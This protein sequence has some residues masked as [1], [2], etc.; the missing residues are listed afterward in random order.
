[1]R[2]WFFLLSGWLG[3]AP[4]HVSH[5]VPLEI[6]QKY[7]DSQMSRKARGQSYFSP[8]QI[9]ARDFVN[10]K[11]QEWTACHRFGPQGMA[12]EPGEI[13][14]DLRAFVENKFLLKSLRDMATYSLIGGVVE[15]QPWSGDYWPYATGILG[16]RPFDA[17]F[18]KL[19]NW[20]ERFQFVNRSTAADLLKLEGAQALHRLS[21]SEKYDLWVGDQ[22]GSL[23]A[24]MWAQGKDYFER[25]GEV[26]AWMG[27]CHGWAAAAIMDSRPTR[28][29]QI[30]SYDKN[31]RIPLR[32]AEMKGLLSYS[33]AKNPY[34]VNFIGKRCEKKDPERDENGR[35]IDPECLDLNPATW[36]LAI[37]NR[38]GIWRKSFVLDTTYDYQV[39]NQPVVAYGYSYFN[40]KT[41]VATGDLSAATVKREE[42]EGDRFAKYRSPEVRQIVGISMVVGYTVETMSDER[43]ED[44]SG[45][46]IIQWVNYRYDLELDEEGEILGGE[47]HQSIHP[48]FLWTPLEGTR[49]ISLLDRQIDGQAWR[50]REEPIPDTWAQAAQVSSSA[51]VVLDKLIRALVKLSNEP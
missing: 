38:L 45:N 51:G 50:G 8:Q 16:A 26:E 27:I 35:L 42:F 44:S 20:L 37:V 15:R 14:N 39:W 28:M 30:V 7:F 17:D 13:S 21:P 29:V 11:S 19:K 9:E 49:P 46:D 4:M 24:S 10:I 5:A 18:L 41:G 6:P 25:F 2:R 1:M 32:P 12:A 3:L 33:W 40:P 36:H 22:N 31:W 48:D 43:T 47:W 23:T 34:A